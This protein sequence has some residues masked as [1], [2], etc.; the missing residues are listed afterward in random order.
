[1]S[2]EVNTYQQMI[3]RNQ[4]EKTAELAE[5]IGTYFQEVWGV[6]WLQLKVDGKNYEIASDEHLKDK[7]FQMVC[8]TLK[9][10]KEIEFSM[11]SCN[12][13][14]YWQRSERY[15]MDIF[16]SNK[17]TELSEYVEYKSTDYYDQDESVSLSMYDDAGFHEP[18]PVE[19]MD[20][21]ED[22]K[23]WFCYTPQIAL[24]EIEVEDEGLYTF[25]LESFTKIK[26]LCGHAEDDFEDVITD[27]LEDCGELIYEAGL[28]FSNDEI[29]TLLAIL[30]GIADKAA[31]NFINFDL[32]INAVPDG[33]NDYNFASVE[34]GL[35]KGIVKSKYYRF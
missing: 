32:A 27:G 28:F 13:L 33:E 7:D 10:A 29:K 26:D 23:Q 20:Y 24:S 25:F 4:N 21:I 18:E 19:D 6:L 3:I 5:K 22:I 31:A 15:F 17:D 1:M 2:V 8:Q 11:R 30:Q 16:S 34:I 12:G 14:D 9:T 35:E